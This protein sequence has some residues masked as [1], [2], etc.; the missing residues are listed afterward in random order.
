MPT[1]LLSTK[2][3]IPRPRPG[4]VTRPRLLSR[5]DAALH[6]GHRLILVSA[7]A[8]S[9]K[10][11][12]LNS[13]LAT[14]DRP[15]VWLSL[16]ASDSDPVRF[17]SYVIA[18][19]QTVDPKIGEGLIGALQAPQPAPLEALLASLANQIGASPALHGAIIVLDDYHVIQAQPVHQVLAFLLEHLPAPPDG[20]HLVVATR[21]DPPVPVS[22]LRGRGMLTELRVAD[23]RFTM[24]EAAAFLAGTMGLDITT[25]AIRELESRTEGWITGLQLAAL[26]LQG[27]DRVQAAR[28]V[29]AFAGSNRHV[30]DY[31]IEEV[32]SRQT[33]PVQ[34]FLLETSILDRLT[35]PL[36]DTVTG[37]GGG[38]VMLESLEQRNVFI[39]PIDDERRRF[40]Y[41]RLFRDL[42]RA[43]LNRWGPQF[44]CA[45][46]PELHRRASM[47]F[48]DQ[49]SL[50]EAID[51]AMQAGETERAA[52]LIED[53]GLRMLTQGELTTLLAWL[54]PL[55]REMIDTRPWLA[56]YAAWALGLT[57][58]VD[59]AEARLQAAEAASPGSSSDDRLGH[60]AAIRTFVA[61]QRGKM[62]DVVA[63]A[64]RALDVLDD[65]NLIVRS[66]VTF[67]VGGAHLLGG[68]WPAAAHAFSQAVEMGQAG[69]NIHLAVSA[70]AQLAMLEVAQG[71][72][73]RAFE[74]CRQMLAMAA[75]LP[76]AAQAYSG[77]GELSY[78][79][80]DLEAADAHLVRSVELGERWG[81]VEGLSGSYL[82]L[83]RLRRVQGDRDGARAA[84]ERAERLVE[85]GLHAGAK[86]A[87][88][89]WQAWCAVME[90]DLTAGQ[91]WVD[92]SGLDAT[93]QNLTMSEEEYLVLAR[94]LLARGDLDTAAH[95]LERILAPAERLGRL[96]LSLRVRALQVL[97]LEAQGDRDLALAILE[98]ALVAAEPEGYMR[99]F[100]DEGEPIRR[101]LAALANKLDLRAPALSAPEAHRL[102]AYTQKLLDAFGGPEESI[103]TLPPQTGVAEPLSERELEVLRLVADGCTNREIA[104]QLFIALSTVKSH[105]NSIYGKLGV[106]NR[107]QAIA[108]ARALGLV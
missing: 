32:L 95:L 65:G 15:A 67:T 50:T 28:F 53:H 76:V 90:G 71:H 61:A 6:L 97:V 73:H 56:I 85:Q 16:D 96:G 19:M 100:M 3:H 38:Q 82:W 68:D 8:G 55:P 12:L 47:W 59:E 79:W 60:I 24:D 99:T 54:Q 69:G 2:L 14:L 4:L 5:L 42:L 9:G 27:R 49:G 70:A 107:T 33:E 101:L 78:E 1:P 64:E 30:L 29:D 36:C 92:A 62:D 45:P 41:H 80:N 86:A 20:M 88:T 91:R 31:L 57:G 63:L 104:G 39:L 35:G 102:R 17:L 22:R 108:A 13:W 89:A 105:T 77:L 93:D 37:S 66:V 106:K 103:P 18:A 74:T 46:A 52:R 26:S 87:V 48:E 72:L 40:H 94:L 7:P 75:D 84:T 34:K 98:Q 43:R 44:G 81:N 21:A 11:T 25:E 10:T 23:L 83:A 51:H 58:Q